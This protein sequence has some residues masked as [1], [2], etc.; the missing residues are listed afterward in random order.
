MPRACSRSPGRTQESPV[1]HR[2]IPRSVRA[3]AWPE[4]VAEVA[5]MPRACSRSPAAP[6]IAGQPP[7][8]AEVVEGV[9]L[10]SRSPSPGRPGCGGD[11]AGDGFDP[12]TSR[13]KSSARAEVVGFTLMCWPVRVTWS[14]QASKLSRSARPR[15]FARH[16]P[17]Q[18]AAAGTGVG[19]EAGPGLAGESGPGRGQRC[20][21]N[22]PGAYQRPF[23]ISG[24]IGC[25]LGRGRSGAS[26][27]AC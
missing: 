8:V 1:S 12:G 11:V 15:Q 25:W 20:A 23:R 22:S 19:I 6:A 16:L 21:G 13:R 17:A 10:L 27:R 14:R 26:G 4:P 18:G 24:G 2:M 3:L 5:V 7:Y 9:G